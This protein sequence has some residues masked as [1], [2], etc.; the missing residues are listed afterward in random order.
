MV[1]LSGLTTGARLRGKRAIVTGASSGIGRA[2]ALLFGAEGASV[3]VCGRDPD[4][5]RATCEAIEAAG[6]SVRRG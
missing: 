2:I 5:T 6:G 3:A 4:R 1:E